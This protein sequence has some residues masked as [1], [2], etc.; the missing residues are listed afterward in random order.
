[1]FVQIGE[2]PNQRLVFTNDWKST[3]Q[4]DGLIALTWHHFLE[5][6]DEP[7]WLLR[8]PMVKGSYRRGTTKKLLEETLNS[9]GILNSIGVRA[10]RDPMS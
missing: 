1:M 4:E 3:R 6:P 10:I 8:F 7:E 5:Y 9:V 2:I